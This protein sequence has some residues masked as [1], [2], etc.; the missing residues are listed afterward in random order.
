MP[1][2]D[3]FHSDSGHCVVPGDPI[4]DRKGDMATFIGVTRPEADQPA[5]VAVHWTGQPECASE[6][7]LSTFNLHVG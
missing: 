3:V 7:P 2:E 1:H 4:M 5:L 6:H